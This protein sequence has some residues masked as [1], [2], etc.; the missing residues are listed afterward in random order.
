[1]G[2]GGT[3]HRTHLHTPSHHPTRFVSSTAPALPIP[4]I[5]SV[6]PPTLYR[7]PPP[8]LLASSP[9]YPPVSKHTHPRAPSF[10]PPPS[11]SLS[12]PPPLLPPPPHLAGSPPLPP[13]PLCFSL[14]PAPCYMFTSTLSLSLWLST[15]PGLVSP[16]YTIIYNISVYL[17]P[18][19]NPP[20]LLLLL[21]SSSS[22]SRRCRAD[23]LLSPTA[24]NLTILAP[25]PLPLTRPWPAS[26]ARGPGTWIVGRAW[27]RGD[28][29]QWCVRQAMA[30]SR[31]GEG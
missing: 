28:S 29:A 13:P 4:L 24:D 21:S 31:A 5:I 14:P 23:D 2:G 10:S 1:M 25:G 7:H 9:S 27:L 26:V 6:L 19:S 18:P 15:R 11:C 16:R 17:P 8:H 20:P 30:E 22:H 3:G 12:I